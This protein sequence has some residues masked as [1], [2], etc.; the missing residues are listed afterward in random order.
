MW[1]FFFGIRFKSQM[2]AIT[3]HCFN[4]G[5]NE[6]MKNIFKKKTVNLIEL[7]LHNNNHG[8]GTLLELS[9]TKCVSCVHRNSKTIAT[10]V[11]NV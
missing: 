1:G 9:I 11:H 5:P 8:D 4:I 6:K 3:G 7:K 10:T 2:T